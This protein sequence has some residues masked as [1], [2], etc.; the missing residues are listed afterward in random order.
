MSDIKYPDKKYRFGV[1]FKLLTE[2]VQPY[3][4]TRKVAH[5]G[6]VRRIPQQKP[7]VAMAI[8]DN[9]SY[10]VML[11]ILYTIQYVVEDKKY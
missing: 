6:T 4:Q 9:G 11:V 8:A 10:V 7:S 5:H 2:Q 1:P 3:V